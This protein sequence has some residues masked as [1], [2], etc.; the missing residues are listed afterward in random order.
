MINI[1]INKEKLIGGSADFKP[2]SN[3]NPQEL[4]MGI[5]HELEHTDDEKIAKEIAK[6]HLSEDPNYYSN[7]KSSGMNELNEAKLS[8]YWRKRAKRRALD[9][10]R[11]WPN[12]KDREWALNNQE[13]SS[14]INKKLSSIYEQELEMTEELNGNLDEFMKKM[15][16]KKSVFGMPNNFVTGKKTKSKKTFKPLKKKKGSGVLKT[17]E[18]K[19]KSYKKQAGEYAAVVASAGPLEENKMNLDKR[20]IKRLI[21]EEIGRK[22]MKEEKLEEAGGLKAAALA[23]LLALAPGAAK[24]D[25]PDWLKGIM[26]GGGKSAVTA[27]SEQQSPVD[28]ATSFFEIGKGQI[29]KRLLKT[30]PELV[31]RAVEGEIAPYEDINGITKDSTSRPDFIAYKYVD[32]EGVATF[33]FFP[34]K[35]KKYLSNFGFSYEMKAIGAPEGYKTYY[36]VTSEGMKQLQGFE[37]KCNTAFSKVDTL[38]ADAGKALKGM[39]T[40]DVNGIIKISIDMAPFF[41]AHPEFKPV[42]DVRT[43]HGSIRDFF[44]KKLIKTVQKKLPGQEISIQTAIHPDDPEDSV[45]IRVG[46]SGGPQRSVGSAPQGGASTV[47]ENKIN[48]NYLRQIIKEAICDMKAQ[49]YFGGMAGAP[50]SMPTGMKPGME[51]KH[52]DSHDIDP[53]GYEGRMAKGNLFKM[54]Q[55]SAKLHNMIQ[56][57][58]N[59][60]PWVEEK[61]AVA[62]SM[63]ETVAHY[64]EY[65]KIRG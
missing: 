29:F 51:P 50:V 27:K 53:D 5:R 52:A 11:E 28:V 21:L 45:A 20:A 32:D 58:E 33:K 3:F 62:A 23:S 4:S 22:Q 15:E 61:I 36:G 6:D 16:E 57:N 47:K 40:E 18:D 42:F 60:E 34:N 1:K 39:K 64:M 44:Q 10:K 14:K 56:D 54:A 49:G 9:A 26:P 65:E 46:G 7:L 35:E 30:E 2:D 41:A 38:V 12:K 48:T 25:V 43:K 19:A 17:I 37:A 24:A 31:K 55:Y 63:I 8:K 13:K 59:L